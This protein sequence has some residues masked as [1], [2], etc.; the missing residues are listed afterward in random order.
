MVDANSENDPKTTL[1][2]ATK[3]F[4]S[5]NER[6]I[7]GLPYSYDIYQQQVPTDSGVINTVT[8]KFPNVNRPGPSITK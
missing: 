7:H 4:P 6:S 3:L 1:L 8:V 5:D 2:L